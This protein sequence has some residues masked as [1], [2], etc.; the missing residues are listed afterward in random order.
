VSRPARPAS[1]PASL[2]SSQPNMKKSPLSRRPGS[3]PALIR[4]ALTTIPDCWACRKIFVSRT[5]GSDPAASRWIVDASCLVSSA[6]RLAA[7]ELLAVFRVARPAAAHPQALADLRAQQRP[8]HRDQVRTSAGVDP[9]Y[10]VP[11][12]R[13]GESDPLHDAVKHRGVV[14]S[15]SFRR[16]TTIMPVRRPAARA[17]W[18][19]WA[20]ACRGF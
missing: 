16:H 13:I 3:C 9:R 7:L 6:R 10:R 1:S 8:H 17:W 15:P 20:A 11:G 14:V 19:G 2:R 12:L 4:C 18:P 5:A